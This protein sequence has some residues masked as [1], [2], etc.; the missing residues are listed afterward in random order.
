M[1]GCSKASN[2]RI[3]DYNQIVNYNGQAG[4]QVFLI[5]I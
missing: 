1:A 2:S 5:K 3:I 4:S